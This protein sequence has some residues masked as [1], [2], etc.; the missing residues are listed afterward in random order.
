MSVAQQSHH[1]YVYHKGAPPPK[2]VS[3]DSRC[4]QRSLLSHFLR[5]GTQHCRQNLRKY[6]QPHTPN[7][8]TGL[9]PDGT[10]DLATSTTFGV[11]CGCDGGSLPA[12][13]PTPGGSCAE[14]SGVTVTSSD[15]PLLEGCLA[16]IDLFTNE[17]PEFLSGTG[18]IVY[19]EGD[20]TV[21]VFVFWGGS[22]AHRVVHV[23]HLPPPRP[24]NP[25]PVVLCSRTPPSWPP[26]SSPESASN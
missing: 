6:F 21:I 18:I 4:Q 25:G 1:V 2:F 13:T 24:Q 5:G 15:F 14:G 10:V 20:T 3:T 16:E 8:L 12:P 22:A 17:G 23:S 19:D 7:T 11:D 9:F 26:L